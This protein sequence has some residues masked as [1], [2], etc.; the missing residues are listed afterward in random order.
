MGFYSKKRGVGS[1]RSVALRGGVNKRQQAYV[2]FSVGGARKLAVKIDSGSI[3]DG[4]R[5]RGCK[6]LLYRSAT[7]D[8]AKYAAR[9]YA[10]DESIVNGTIQRNGLAVLTAQINVSNLKPY[11]DATFIAETND[12]VSTA[13]TYA[14]ASFFRGGRG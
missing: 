1:S 13:A 12:V 9:F 14:A 10:P 2:V 6:F 11:V 3:Y 5:S 4:A 8:P 7:G